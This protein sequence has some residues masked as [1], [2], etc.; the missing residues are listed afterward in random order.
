MLA[1]LLPIMNCILEKE[2]RRH[3]RDGAPSTLCNKVNVKL[4]T[5]TTLIFFD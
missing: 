1:N 2:S 5:S 4:E 3:G